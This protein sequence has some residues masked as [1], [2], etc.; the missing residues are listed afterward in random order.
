MDI[1]SRSVRSR[2]MR[3]IRSSDTRP[4]LLVRSAAHRLGLRFRLHRR[5]LPGT[6][7]LVFPRHRTVVFVHGCFWHR[8]DCGLAA[9]PK[10]RKRF[11]TEKFAANVMRDEK[12]RAELAA[13]GWRVIEIWECETRNSSSVRRRLQRAFHVRRLAPAT[14]KRRREGVKSSIPVRCVAASTA[15]AAR[16]SGHGT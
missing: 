16:L 5:D 3:G 10:T 2:M 13:Q 1:V 4:E 7:D 8:H 15:R 9:E 6:P 11:W 12:N 14:R